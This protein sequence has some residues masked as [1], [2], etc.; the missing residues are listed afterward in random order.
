MDRVQAPAQRAIVAAT[1]AGH[2]RIVHGEGVPFPG[3]AAGAGNLQ[4]HAMGLAAAVRGGGAPAEWVHGARLAALA[5]SAPRSQGQLINACKAW[6]AFVWAMRG[7][8]SRSLPPDVDLLVAWSVLCGSHR[9]CANY[10]SKLRLACLIMKASRLSRT[11]MLSS[12]LSGCW[13]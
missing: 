6:A 10:I 1:A 11:T 4:Q 8:G 3:I 9:T 13:Q 5:G 12:V 2:N 7:Q